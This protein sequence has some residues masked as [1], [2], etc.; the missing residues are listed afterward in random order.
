METEAEKLKQMLRT[1]EMR[2]QPSSWKD[3]QGSEDE[4]KHLKEKT[5]DLEFKLREE[6]RRSATF[7]LQV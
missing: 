2:N 6:K 5:K 4:A 1:E 7:E 3:H